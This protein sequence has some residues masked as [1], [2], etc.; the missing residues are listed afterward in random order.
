MTFTLFLMTVEIVL[1]KMQMY[2]N[3][4]IEYRI[5]IMFTVTDFVFD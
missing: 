2:K 3:C 1:C 5:K 4:L